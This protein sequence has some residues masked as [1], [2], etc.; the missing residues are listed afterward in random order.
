MTIDPARMGQLPLLADGRPIYPS[1]FVMCHLADIVYG[2]ILG[3]EKV[4]GMWWP[5]GL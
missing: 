3:V 1:R 2:K 5:I 4:V